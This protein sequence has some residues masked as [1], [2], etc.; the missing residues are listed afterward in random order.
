VRLAASNTPPPQATTLPPILII[1]QITQ[2]QQ[3]SI[4][5]IIAQNTREQQASIVRCQPPQKPTTTAHFTHRS[6]P[7]AGDTQPLATMLLETPVRPNTQVFLMRRIQR[8]QNRNRTTA[9]P[10]ESSQHPTQP[11]PQGTHPTRKL[12]TP[13]ANNP[14]EANHTPTRKTNR[15]PHSR[16]THW[17]QQPSKAPSETATSVKPF[18]FPLP[19]PNS[20]EASLSSHVGEP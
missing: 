2:E 16:I 8:K 1:A 20:K 15:K 12:P 5:L 9:N 7:T 13:T 17:I 6:Q 14:A 19:E 18:I 4:V 11:Q 3:A 10:S